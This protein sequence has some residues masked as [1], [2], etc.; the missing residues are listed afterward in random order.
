M[1]EP[2][3]FWMKRHTTKK[4]LITS[5]EQLKQGWIKRWKEMPQ[6]NIQAWIERI[7]SYIKDVIRLEGGNEYKEGRLKGKVKNR[8]GTLN[9]EGIALEK[10]YNK[11][12]G[13]RRRIGHKDSRNH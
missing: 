8:L 10:D 6:E 9:T 3:W 12:Y 1:I 4:G 5:R 11:H 13:N 2:C 7:I